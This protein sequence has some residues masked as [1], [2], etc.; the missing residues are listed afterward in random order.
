MGLRGSSG[1]IFH[2]AQADPAPCLA[3]LVKTLIAIRTLANRAMNP[4]RVK[5]MS[6]NQVGR[7]PAGRDPPF[8]QTPH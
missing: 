7:S 4:C 3:N 2:E 5:K 1:F 8:S 6:T